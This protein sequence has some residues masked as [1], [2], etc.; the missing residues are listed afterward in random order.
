MTPANKT[1][2][3]ETDVVEQDALKEATAALEKLSEATSVDEKT[4]MAVDSSLSKMNRATREAVIATPAFQKLIAQV[5]EQTTGKPGTI[6]QL[7]QFSAIK[8][9]YSLQDVYDTY[10]LVDSYVAREDITVVY[11]GWQF[12]LHDG[13]IYDQP[14]DVPPEKLP[15]GHGYKLPCIVTSILDERYTQQRS[16]KRQY[17]LGN[18]FS[19][20]V[21]Y[22]GAGWPGKETVISNN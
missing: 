5:A 10:P 16:F 8:V 15:E 17:E 13:I 6:R 7:G 1:A 22:L 20:G 21:K 2:A 11:G 4:V 19:L 18:E 12:V 3:D 14:R 9:P